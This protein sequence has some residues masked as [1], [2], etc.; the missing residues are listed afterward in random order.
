MV[1]R[2]RYGHG[3]ERIRLERCPEEVAEHE[4]DI[5]APGGRCFEGRLAIC[6]QL[7]PDD[8]VVIGQTI[9]EER[10]EPAT[11]RRDVEDPAA[12]D[13]AEDVARRRRGLL[14]TRVFLPVQAASKR[15]ASAA[16]KRRQAGC[17]V[18]ARTLSP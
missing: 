18:G 3:V 12:V 4:P 2:C 10:D 11:P 14:H 5:A 15:V 1:Q 17:P 7:D 13:V 8:L 16:V 9:S 6:V